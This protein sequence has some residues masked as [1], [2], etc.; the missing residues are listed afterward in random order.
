[1]QGYVDSVT[2]DRVEGWAWDPS[3]PETAIALKVYDNGVAIGEV[4]ANLLRD[5]L[6][7]SG[8]GRGM[9]GIQ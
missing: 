1:M 5:D 3:D 7:Q 9:R 4:T 6:R 8:I 2:L